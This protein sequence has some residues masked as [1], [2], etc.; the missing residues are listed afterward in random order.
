MNYHAAELQ[1]KLNTIFPCLLFQ[2]LYTPFYCTE[3]SDMLIIE[4]KCFK[5]VETEMNIQN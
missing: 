2:E 1:K 3:K 5:E 4:N